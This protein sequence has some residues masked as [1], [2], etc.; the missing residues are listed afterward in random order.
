MK[1]RSRIV[2]ISPPIS[3]LQIDATRLIHSLSKSQYI[4]DDDQGYP[5]EY[6]DEDKSS[7]DSVP[8]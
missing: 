8:F 1:T 5:D 2:S 7:F 6:P 3:L 4:S